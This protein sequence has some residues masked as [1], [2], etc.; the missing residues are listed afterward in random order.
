M[1]PNVLLLTS[2]RLSACVYRYSDILNDLLTNQLKGREILYRLKCPWMF[3]SSLFS[4]FNSNIFYWGLILCILLAYFLL[5]S[6]LLTINKKRLICLSAVAIFSI[7]FF[8]NN[9]KN[10]LLLFWKKWKDKIW[11][12]DFYDQ[13]S[14]PVETFLIFRFIFAVE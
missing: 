7:S 10:L 12:Q 3:L 11:R 8:K 2:R 6:I 9:F 5:S 4:R 14:L 1:V 13:Y